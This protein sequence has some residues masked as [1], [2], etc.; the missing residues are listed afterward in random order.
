MEYKN[1]TKQNIN[2]N[3]ALSGDYFV[4]IEH[5]LPIIPNL[6][7]ERID[8]IKNH[9]QTFSQSSVTAYYRVLNL[10]DISLNLGVSGNYYDKLMISNVKLN[11]GWVPSLYAN[12]EI[13]IPNT[14]ISLFASINKGQLDK[15]RTFNGDA[16]IKYTIDTS[17]IKMNVRTGYRIL[18]DTFYK[19]KAYKINM[20]GI[21][22]GVGFDI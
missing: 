8:T 17:L 16:G 19:N 20:K 2:S 4:S 3:N 12:S 15:T 5:F 22:I 6:R 11:N 13:S 1:K 7:I 18:N 14:P 21:F 10:K 9:N